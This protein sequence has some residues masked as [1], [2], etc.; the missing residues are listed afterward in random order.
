MFFGLLVQKN[1]ETRD[2]PVSALAARTKVN[3]W[4]TRRTSGDSR[5]RSKGQKIGAFRALATEA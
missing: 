4:Q 5:F 3:Q 2:S 1:S